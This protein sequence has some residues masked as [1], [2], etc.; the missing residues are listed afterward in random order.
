MRTPIS[1][2]LA[3]ALLLAG[4]PAA[5]ATELPDAIA[6]TG[7]WADHREALEEFLREAEIVSIEEIGMGVN[8]PDKVTLERDGRTLHAAW[9]QIKT[10]RLGG[11]WESWEAEVAAYELDKLLGLNMVPPTVVRRIKG[12]RGSLQLWVNDC[13]LYRDLHGQK[14][15][16]P[17][18]WRTQKSRMEIFDN[19]ILNT[20]RN[21]QNI[22]VDA[23]WGMVLIDHSRAFTTRSRLL[24]DEGQVPSWFD[25]ALVERVRGLTL[26]QL[27]D[28]LDGFMSKKQCKSVLKRR[29]AL[30]ARVDALV[31]Q[32]GEGA[33]LF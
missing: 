19:L 33:V 26:E 15:Q 16:S 2:A 20:D 21:A 18:R 10:G 3:L 13:R 23:E 25:R 24:E 4:A 29:D 1:M 30:L 7:G 27:R 12:D 22:L 17:T 28:R 5:V 32:H 9:K 14:V 31:A 6:L 8:K 11:S